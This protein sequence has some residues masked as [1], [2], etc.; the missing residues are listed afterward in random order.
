MALALG[1]QSREIWQVI[2]GS[3]SAELEPSETI[4]NPIF[5]IFAFIVAPMLYR[6]AARCH[7]HGHYVC[8]CGHYSSVRVYASA[9]GT[10]HVCAGTWKSFL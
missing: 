2:A 3:F 5:T 9:R 6:H 10:V 1:V 4:E 8:A 7:S